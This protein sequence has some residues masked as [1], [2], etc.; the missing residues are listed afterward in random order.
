MGVGRAVL[1]ALGP[2]VAVRSSEV[3]AV[4]AVE[5]EQQPVRPRDPHSYSY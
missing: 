5:E 3:A 4:V 1:L 2:V